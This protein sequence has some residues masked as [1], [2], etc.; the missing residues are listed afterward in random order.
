MSNTQLPLT[1][2]S[3]EDLY[4]V[5]LKA[6]YGAAFGVC[7]GD[8]KLYQRITSERVVEDAVQT[9]LTRE[10]HRRNETGEELLTPQLIKRVQ[11]R[12]EDRVTKGPSIMI[13]CPLRGKGKRKAVGPRV[14][15]RELADNGQPT[16]NTVYVTA[17]EQRG[18]KALY[19]SLEE[20]PKHPTFNEAD[21]L[22]AVVS[23]LPAR[24]RQYLPEGGQVKADSELGSNPRRVRRELAEAC[25]LAIAYQLADSQYC[26]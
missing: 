16:G 3:F 22:P 11:G 5:L 4:P 8:G 12:V 14:P 18:S 2:V 21:H 25:R 23:R 24:L 26:N 6:G 10:V 13:G 20:A 9:E 17:P 7:A 15:V 19:E 1:G